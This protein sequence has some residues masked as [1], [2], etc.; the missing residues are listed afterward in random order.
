M[1]ISQLIKILTRIQHAEG[2]LEVKNVTLTGG[3]VDYIRDID[4][5]VGY[6]DSDYELFA[7]KEDFDDCDE[8]DCDW[9]DEAIKILGFVENED[10]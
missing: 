1:H 7:Y 5:V 3:D 2:D 4:P 10:Y 8:D 9:K 6:V